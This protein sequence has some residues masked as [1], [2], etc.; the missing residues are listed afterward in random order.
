MKSSQHQ[1]KNLQFL[2]WPDI[3][4]HKKAARKRRCQNLTLLT[5]KPL[6]I[7]L[8]VLSALQDNRLQIT[9]TAHLEEIA[10]SGLFILIFQS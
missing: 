4:T 2:D 8:F 10:I 9:S 1:C 7:F 3:V 6:Q 5:V